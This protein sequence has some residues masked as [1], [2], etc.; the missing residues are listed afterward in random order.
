MGRL[1]VGYVEVLWEY[2]NCKEW[3]NPVSQTRGY[4]MSHYTQT[5]GLS[6]LIT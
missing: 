1:M 4:T 3:N 6:P 2:Y 5:F